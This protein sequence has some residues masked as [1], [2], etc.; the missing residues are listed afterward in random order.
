MRSSFDVA[1]VGAGPAGAAAAIQ[2]ARQ[3]L[4]VLLFERNEVG[5]TARCANW[6]ENL[7]GHPR[8]ITGISFSKKLAAQLA[9]HRV[10]VVGREVTGV[11]MVRSAYELSAGRARFSSRAVIVAC[12]LVGKKLGIPG[13]EENAR[14]VVPYPVPQKTAH[15]G[16]R[17][18]VIGGGD[19]AFDQAI[20]FSSK[21]ASVTI[22]M[23]GESPRSIPRLVKE[24]RRRGVRIVARHRPL[25][26][27]K[28][29]QSVSVVF[30]VR[31]KRRSVVADLVALC[32]GRE[33]GGARLWR[34]ELRGSPNLFFAGD[35][36][37]KL[38]RHVTTAAGDGIDKAMAAF[39]SLRR[40]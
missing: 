39:D 40:A 2:A 35:C 25:E 29:G 31:G 24:A 18:L 26:I 5:G 6:I 1:I 30:S 27:V 3:G 28:E 37:G 33:E 7:P 20:G 34:R 15:R 17:V 10:R 9:R 36:T 12:G 4:S 16:K 11:R 23:R 22:A 13:E 19:T 8:G 38:A 14:L 32:V 21:A